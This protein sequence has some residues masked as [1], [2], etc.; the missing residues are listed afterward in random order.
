MSGA[1]RVA[2]AAGIGNFLQGWDNA[3]I[4][5]AILY[6]KSDFDVESAPQIEGLIIAMSLIGAVLVTTCSGVLTD[7]LGRRPLLIVSSLFYFFS[8]FVMLW[9][10]NVYIL[11]LGRLLDG[12]GTGLAVTVVPIYISETAPAEVRGLLNI[13]PQFAGCLGMFLSYCMIFGMSFVDSPNWRL[14]LGVLSIPS[15]VYFILTMFYMPESPRWLV[16]KGCLL[17][18]KNVLRTLR[19]QEDISDELAM[20]VEGLGVGGDISIEKYMICPANEPIAEDVSSTDQIKLYGLGGLSW[21]AQ[22]INGESSI[23]HQEGIQKTTLLMDPL[24]TLFA[25]VNEKLPDVGIKGSMFFPHLGSIFNVAN[26]PNDEEWDEENIAGEGE[27]DVSDAGGGDSD[28]DLQSPLISRQTTSMEKDMGPPPSHGTMFGELPNNP[29]SS[30]VPESDSSIGGGWQIAWKWMELEDSNQN[31]HGGFKRLFFLFVD[32]LEARRGSFLSHPV[33]VLPS[34][35]DSVQ[36]IALVS[37]PAL[38]RK[39]LMEQHLIGPAMIYPCEAAR[40]EPFLSTISETGVKHALFIG[41][42]IQLLQQLSG[43]N[44]VLNYTPQI[45]KEAGAGVILAD[46]G[47]SSNS[48]SLLMSAITA[49]LML[50]CFAV[51]MR[52]ADFSGR[53][54]MLLS[55]IPVLIMTLIILLVT[56]VVKIG[57]IADAAISTVCIVLYFCFFAVGFGPIPN[58]ICSEIFPTRFRGTCVAIC[59]LGFFVCNAIVTYTLPLMLSSIGL[60]GVFGIFPIMCAI[61]WLFVFSKVPET[62]CMPLEVIA[63]LFSLRANQETA[64]KINQGLS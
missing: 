13:L 49:L 37:Q 14:I 21:V 23:S 28:E 36:G 63:E 6:I 56:R 17:E 58:I 35:V 57:S 34:A 48:A 61:S 62:R 41:V 9:S 44:G 38:Y 12:F 11:F 52:L 15:I 8:G 26:Q 1:L 60:A 54:S 29:G 64:S 22:P 32:G 2:L 55:T 24:V 16:S 25:N 33:Y 40:E 30:R 7:K 42:G 10:P 43:I 39:D 53:R 20:L 46:T 50:P 18:A 4:S 31:V 27:E 47:I 45:L 5:G 19:C 3:A 59:A 51:A